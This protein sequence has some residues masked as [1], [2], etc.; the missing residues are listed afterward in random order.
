MGSCQRVIDLS[1]LLRDVF[2]LPRHFLQFIE[3]IFVCHDISLLCCITYSLSSAIAMMA[4]GI[5]T[6][7]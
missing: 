6:S 4:S 5:C 2:I 7:Y 1:F 3:S